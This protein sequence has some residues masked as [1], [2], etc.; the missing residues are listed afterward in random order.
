MGEK[1]SGSDYP[2]T[3]KEQC[4]ICGKP[5]KTLRHRQRCLHKSEAEIYKQLR[6]NKRL[7]AGKLHLWDRRNTKQGKV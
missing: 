2:M 4:Q 3:E 6:Y 7:E 1:S 5:D